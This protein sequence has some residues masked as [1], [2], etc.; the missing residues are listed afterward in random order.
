M[1]MGVWL[2]VM[3]GGGGWWVWQDRLA[4]QRFQTLTDTGARQ[5]VYL[6]WIAQSF[7]ILVGASIVSLWLAGGLAPF[8]GYPAAF[9]PL[10][11]TL[12]PRRS[13]G[14][15][16][17][18]PMLVGLTIGVGVSVAVQ[19]W[20]LRR[21]MVT[22]AGTTEALLP[23]NRRE[24]AIALL[25]SANA[26][27]SE[28]LFFRLALPLLLFQLTHAPALSMGLS[29]LCFGLAHAYQ[30]WKGILGTMAAGALLTLYYCSHGS[31]VRVM[32]VHALIDVIALL[33]RPALT[34]LFARRQSPRWLA[35]AR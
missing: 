13:A 9:E 30:G 2:T 8:D 19:W 28:E 6:R 25:L 5:R 31:L 29:V 22:N 14:D 17:M 20:R 16:H 4:Y 1:A 26:G 23:R 35:L 12:Q 7:T 24:G 3:I 15:G 10:R 34:D 11:L 33:V 27:F 21:M 18:L 32:L